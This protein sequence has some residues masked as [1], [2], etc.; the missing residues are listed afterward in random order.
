[1][2]GIAI[3]SSTMPAARRVVL[4]LL[5]LTSFAAPGCGGRKLET[6]YQYTPL[7]ATPVQRRAYYAGPF[8]PE[9]RD[10]MMSRDA[11]APAGGAGGGGGLRGR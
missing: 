1:M 11:D 7:G 4:A 8:S 3:A 9:A 2:V 5:V 10:A 6:G